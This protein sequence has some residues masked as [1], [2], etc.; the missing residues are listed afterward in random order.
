MIRPLVQFALLSC[1]AL[2]CNREAR[3]RDQVLAEALQ[4]PAS[5]LCQIDNKEGGG[6]NGDCIARAASH[7]ASLYVRASEVYAALPTSPEP[8]IEA[9]LREVREV[10]RKLGIALGPNCPADVESADRAS[11]QR[12]AAVNAGVMFSQLR[13]SL[14]TLQE[15]VEAAS[16][17][18]LPDPNWPCEDAE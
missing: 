11:L 4:A 12:C 6:C 14:D 13:S 17:V 3:Q 16:G 7:T 8:A 2:A 9:A 5:L 10:S 15:R 1:V 18:E